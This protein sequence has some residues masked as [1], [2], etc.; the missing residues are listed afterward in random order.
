[1]KGRNY[2]CGVNVKLPKGSK[3][4]ATVTKPIGMIVWQIPGTCLLQG[5]NGGG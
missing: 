4:D 3:Y 5:D 2:V 1:M